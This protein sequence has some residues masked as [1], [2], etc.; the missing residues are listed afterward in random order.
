MPRTTT[1]RPGR[2]VPLAEGSVYAHLSIKTL[3]RYIA[4]GRITGYR[5]GVKLIQVDLDEIDAIIKPVPAAR[6][7]AA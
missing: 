3:R 6:N 5:A 2:R 4:D 1:R 7:G